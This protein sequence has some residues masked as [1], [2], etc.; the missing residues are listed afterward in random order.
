LRRS[1]PAASPHPRQAPGLPWKIYQPHVQEPEHTIKIQA[2]ATGVARPEITGFGLNYLK[3][4]M[5]GT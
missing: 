5:F 4:A 1:L 3:M 2:Q